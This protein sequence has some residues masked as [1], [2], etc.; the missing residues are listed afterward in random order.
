M[1][2]SA[3]PIFPPPRIT[4]NADLGAPL[5]PILVGSPRFSILAQVARRTSPAVCER[6]LRR[7]EDGERSG[8][9]EI[10]AGQVEIFAG[11]WVL[12]R[13]ERIGIMGRV[14][15]IDAPTGVGQTAFAIAFFRDRNWIGA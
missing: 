11:Q 15:K 12:C 6:V 2:L 13:R 10:F 3:I 9:V 4:T 1:P 5:L 14:T 7:G 8:R